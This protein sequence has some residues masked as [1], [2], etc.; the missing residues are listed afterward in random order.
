MRGSLNLLNSGALGGGWYVALVLLVLL[1][2]VVR[3]LDHQSQLL[4]CMRG[5][6]LGD[7]FWLRDVPGHC[8]HKMYTYAHEP[9]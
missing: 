6:Q 5:V 9:L 3:W 4:Y 8:R 2:L 7:W 1:A